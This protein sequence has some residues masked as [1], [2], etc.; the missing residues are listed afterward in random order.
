MG[1]VCGDPSETYGFWSWI[2]LISNWGMAERSPFGRTDGVDRHLWARCSQNSTCYA[3]CSRQLTVAEL[4]TRQE[5]IL[6]FRRNLND[7]EMTRIAGLRGTIAHINSLNRE[8]DS[9]FW[10]LEGKGNFTVNTGYRMAMEDDLENQNTLRGN[11]FFLVT[12]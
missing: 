10:K 7:W 8:T 5:W 11:F 9:L 2:D 12:G 3:K 6:H 1:L 4:W